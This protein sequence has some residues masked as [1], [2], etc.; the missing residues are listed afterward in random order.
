[1]TQLLLTLLWTGL[2]VWLLAVVMT[3][4]ALLRPAR[5]TPARALARLGWMT[6]ADWGIAF[7]DEEV[8]VRDARSG[9]AMRLAAWWM[10]AAGGS[11]ATAVLVHGY[12]DS[13]AGVMPWAAALLRAGVHVLAVDLRA[14]GESEGRFTTAGLLE[15]DDLGQVLDHLRAQRPEQARHAFLAGVSMGAA[16]ALAA[17]DGREDLAGVIL[18]SPVVDFYLG[19]ERQLWLMGLAGP[20]VLTPGLWLAEWWIGRRFAGIRPVTLLSRRRCPALALLPGED[21]FLP[22]ADADALVAAIDRP[23]GGR[24]ADDPS[25]AVRFPAAGH[26]QPM[27]ID[28][29]RYAQALQPFCA[30]CKS[31][32]LARAP[33][34]ASRPT[35]LTEGSHDA[36]GDVDPPPAG[37]RL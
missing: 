11:D 14:H 15:A 5:M 9:R 7:G 24:A 18:D 1:M 32:R 2:L 13:R 12:A 21:L 30:A 35:G 29:A 6:P 25:A 10:P 4:W 34:G 16:V 3:A 23:A 37:R 19:A 22:P 28:P 26:M 27:G 8:T 33:A 36:T 17:A 31:A 20:S